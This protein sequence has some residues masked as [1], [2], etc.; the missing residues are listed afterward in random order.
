M[1]LTNTMDSTPLLSQSSISYKDLKSLFSS[2]IFWI[3]TIVPVLADMT[4]VSKEPSHLSSS[5]SH[6][7]NFSHLLESMEF[8]KF[9]I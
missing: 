3:P 9:H 7:P 4:S 2:M 1:H 6:L 8:Y 5:I